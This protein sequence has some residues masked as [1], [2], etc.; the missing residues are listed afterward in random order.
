MG[1]DIILCGTVSQRIRS[2][3][4]VLGSFLQQRHPVVS[5]FVP[6][7]QRNDSRKIEHNDLMAYVSNIFGNNFQIFIILILPCEIF[8]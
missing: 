6:Y 5:S 3:L 8:L 1:S 7:E 2:C 4:Q